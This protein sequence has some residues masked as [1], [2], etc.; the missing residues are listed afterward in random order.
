MKI[1]N[2][3]SAHKKRVVGR[4]THLGVQP[5]NGKQWICDDG[6]LADGRNNPTTKTS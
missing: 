2:Y 3:E 1:K 6:G 4:Q 5:Q